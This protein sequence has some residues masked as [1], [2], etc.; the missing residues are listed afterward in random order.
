MK[1]TN[2][3]HWVQDLIDNHAGDILNHINSLPLTKYDKLSLEIKA[4]QLLLDVAHDVM[5]DTK[6]SCMKTFHEALFKEKKND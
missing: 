3:S 5:H 1:L 6:D 2:E 4:K